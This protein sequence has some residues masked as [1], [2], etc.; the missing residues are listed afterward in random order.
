MVIIVYMYV[1]LHVKQEARRQPT[2][3]RIGVVTSV[4]SSYPQINPFLLWK[5]KMQKIR[6]GSMETTL[7]T[8]SKLPW[9]AYTPEWPSNNINSQ[10]THEILHL[11]SP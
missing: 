4:Q 7:K 5:P 1:G 9:L 3:R 6:Q 2:D 10:N 11:L 8:P